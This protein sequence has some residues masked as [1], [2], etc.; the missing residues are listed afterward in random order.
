MSLRGSIMLT[1]KNYAS[2]GETMP[3]AKNYTPRG[4]GITPSAF[5]RKQ[6]IYI[7]GSIIPDENSFIWCQI[8]HLVKKCPG[9]KTSMN[10]NFN[11]NIMPI[12]KNVHVRG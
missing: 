9:I 6:R 11:A 2:G 1:N 12:A 4:G 3:M 10:K 8:M 5:F 7:Q